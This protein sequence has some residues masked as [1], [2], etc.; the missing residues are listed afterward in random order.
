MLKR[1]VFMAVQSI[2]SF[3]ADDCL[4]LAAVVAFYAALSLAPV[5]TI[6]LTLLDK[7]AGESLD[8]KQQIMNQVQHLAG[9]AGARAVQDILDHGGS[10][11]GRGMAAVVGVITLLFG[12]TAVFAALQKA[13]NRIWC[14]EPTRGRQFS[15]WIRK[16]L[17]S[18]GMLLAIGLLLLVSLVLALVINLAADSMSGLLPGSQA[19][20]KLAGFASGLLIVGLLFAMIFKVLPDAEVAW[21]DVWIGAAVTAV[22]FALGRA[23]MGLY[24]RHSDVGSAYGAAGSL[25]VLLLWVYYSSMIMFLGAEFTEVYA[26]MGGRRISPSAHAV[27]NRS[28]RPEGTLHPPG[29]DQCNGR[30]ATV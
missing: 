20:W 23:M 11:R 16:R 10:Q 21:R 29:E 15:T 7:T 8:A 17:L 12:A 19:L 3:G 18:L 24:L 4:S 5:L 22:L 25:V 9:P 26:A 30:P 28:K 13:M 27:V 6:S 1:L 14:V 2:R